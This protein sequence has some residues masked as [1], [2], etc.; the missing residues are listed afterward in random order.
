MEKTEER[1]KGGKTERVADRDKHKNDHKSETN[2]FKNISELQDTNTTC[3]HTYIHT[4]IHTCI[5]GKTKKRSN[6]FD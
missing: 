6:K 1:M 3:M 4:Y 5:L 2:L